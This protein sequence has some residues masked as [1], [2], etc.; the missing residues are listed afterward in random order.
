MQMQYVALNCRSVS[1]PLLQLAKVAVLE[2]E[3][4]FPPSFF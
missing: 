2:C 3:R 4:F 1:V